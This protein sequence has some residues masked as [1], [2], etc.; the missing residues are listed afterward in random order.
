VLKI[1]KNAALVAT[2]A[3]MVLAGS[4]SADPISYSAVL[5]GATTG[6][7][8]D[9]LDAISALGGDV[10]TPTGIGVTFGG[11]AGW[12]TGSLANRYAA[13]FLSGNNGADFGN[14]G[15]GADT[16]QYLS[17]GIGSVT[18][19][20]PGS[21]TYDY[22]GLLWGSVDSY[23]TLTFYNGSTLIGSLTGTDVL[24]L[25]SGDQ[26]VNGTVYVNLGFAPGSGFNKVV[27]SSSNYAFEF[28][29]VAYGN[30]AP[31]PEPA[32]L[33]LFGTGLIGVGR[34]FRKRRG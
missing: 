23:D 33:L 1:V 4:A 18:M 13:P 10:F 2:L 8:K 27:A 28:D 20:M 34:A 21:G 12:A 26:G 22:L 15:S 29:N 16:T 11:D 7:V 31:V 30:A 5:G 17:T 6:S 3:V 14:A 25:A 9:N 24:P 19:A 32:S